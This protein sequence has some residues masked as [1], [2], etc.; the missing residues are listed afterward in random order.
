MIQL[1]RDH[2]ILWP[3]NRLKE[4]RIGVKTSGIQNGV[5][6]TQKLTDPLLQCFMNALR[7]TDKPH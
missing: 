6:H 5:F 1:V 7:A 3:E 2:R 4:A